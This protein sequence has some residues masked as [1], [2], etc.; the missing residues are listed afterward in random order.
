MPFARR[1]SPVVVLLLLAS[2]AT[3]SAECAWVLWEKSINPT[4]VE[5]WR[6]Q[7]AY[8]TSSTT[9]ETIGAAPTHPGCA[10]LLTQKVEVW[11]IELRARGNLVIASP[12]G[13]DLSSTSREPRKEGEQRPPDSY[14]HSYYYFCFP[15]T[16]DPRA[17]KGK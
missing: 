5:P 11:T 16:V 15:D 4:W 17:P 7:R 6:G 1:A 14:V 9:W 2:V 8:W 10:R 13:S 12:D 3:A